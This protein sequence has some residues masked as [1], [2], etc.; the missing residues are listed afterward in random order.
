[1]SKECWWDDTDRN[2]PVL[3]LY[4][5]LFTDISVANLCIRIEYGLGM[6]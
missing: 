3:N 6:V 2:D 5:I 1:M 4:E